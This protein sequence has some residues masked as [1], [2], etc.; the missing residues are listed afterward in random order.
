MT[1]SEE[2]T[3]KAATVAYKNLQSGIYKLREA[4]ENKKVSGLL[5]TEAEVAAILLALNE[6]GYTK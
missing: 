3:K 6:F 1:T 4:L 5:I 2:E